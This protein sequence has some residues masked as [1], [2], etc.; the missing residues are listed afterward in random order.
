MIRFTRSARNSFLALAALCA[1]LMALIGRPGGENAPAARIPA[2][3]TVGLT[4]KAK[5]SDAGTVKKLPRKDLL[6]GDRDLRGEVDLALRQDKGDHYEVPLTGEGT[7]ILTLD[8]KVQHAADKVLAQAKSP[9]GAIV[10]MRTDGRILAISGRRQGDAEQNIPS[11]ENDFGL[12]LSVWAPA[13]SIFKII[14][15]SALL[16]AGVKA[17]EKVCYHGGLRSVDASNLVDNARIDNACNDLGYGLAKSQNALIAKLASNHLDGKSLGAMA[18]KFG[19]GKSPGFA[20]DAEPGR[21][22]LPTDKLEF[23]KVSAGFW[24]TELSP[25]SAAMAANIIASEGMAVT[26][27]IVAEIREKNRVIP[28]VTKVPERVIEAAVARSVGEMMTG[29]V[30]YGTAFKAF[31]DKRGRAYLGETM[32]A[33]KTG[34]LS[35]DT[36]SYLA[37][38]WFV[39]YAPADDP[40]VVVA[41]LLGNSPLWHL[42]AHT[43]ARLLL[44]SLF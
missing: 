28:V 1:L 20:L 32:V 33:G 31:H 27:R 15:A 16:H 21:I 4:G 43:A 19:F 8:P 17:D 22:E 44:D 12:A 6:V 37:Y 13:A 11:K 25:L 24:S 30:R 29:T 9:M 41:V 14:T 5:Q 40:Q 36:P 35:R 18:A 39:G 34:S 23:A 26:P 42:K 10:V 3:K 2:S 38:S 7:A